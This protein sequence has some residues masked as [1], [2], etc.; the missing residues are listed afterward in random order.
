MNTTN[1][2]FNKLFSKEEKTE[3]ET[4]KVEL[5]AIDDFEKEFNKAMSLQTKAMSSTTAIDSAAKKS[6]KIYDSAGK[7]FLKANARYLEIENMSKELG[8]DVP[9]K[10]KNMKKALSESIKE[11][12][13]ASKNLLRIEKIDFV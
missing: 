13:N 12:D 7:S 11:I 2:I 4:H 5:G 10:V 8:V 3:L 1:V 6:L 9:S